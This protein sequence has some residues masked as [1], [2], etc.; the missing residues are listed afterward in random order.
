MK[1]ITVKLHGKDQTLGELNVRTHT[2]QPEIIQAQ[3]DVNYE[4]YDDATG[5][6]PDHIVTKREG[7]DLYVSFEE[8][9]QNPDLIIEDFYGNND[10]GLIGLAENGEYYYYVPDT[11]EVAQYVTNL[12]PG[13]IEGQA[14]GGSSFV[15]P[16]W[17]ALPAAASIPFA[18]GLAGLASIGAIAAVASSNGSDSNNKDA[19]T[20]QTGN[21]TAAVT[22]VELGG[23]AD[24]GYLNAKE[25]GGQDSV[26]VPVTIGLNGDVKEGD[27]V[28]IDVNGTL[29]THT[30]TADEANAHSITASVDIPSSQDGTVVVKASVTATAT[31]NTPAANSAQDD[32][33]VDTGVPGDVNGDKTPNGADNDSTTQDGAPKVSIKDGGDNALNQLT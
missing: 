14:L 27:T 1:N 16:F 19:S 25:V 5:V 11:G 20:S 4:F 23:S 31:G 32:V 15:V 9:G 17:L 28:T 30:V 22:G 24:D 10:Q 21:S 12:T 18:A 8:E 33:I 3:K 7:N 29:S 26:S 6:A 13:M 2:G